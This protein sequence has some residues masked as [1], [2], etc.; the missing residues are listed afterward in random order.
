MLL[1]CLFF[2]AIIFGYV[3]FL[4]SRYPKGFPPH[5]TFSLPIFGDILSLGTNFPKGLKALRAKHGDIFG[6]TFGA[7]TRR[8]T[9]KSWYFLVER[10][11]H[12]Y[13]IILDL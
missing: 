11:F 5:P 3:K 1:I 13:V 12:E 8:F 2:T 10:L 6:F 9:L 4:W 7:H